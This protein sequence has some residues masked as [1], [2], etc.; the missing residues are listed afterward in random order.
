MGFRK[1][2]LGREARR[3]IGLVAIETPVGRH[4]DAGWSPSRRRLVAV[5]ILGGT[6]GTPYYSGLSRG[7]EL[8]LTRKLPSLYKFSHHAF[9]LNAPKLGWGCL[10]GNPNSSCPSI[11][12]P[13]AERVLLDRSPRAADGARG[14][15]VGGFD[16]VLQ[17]SLE[18][19][20]PTGTA[21]DLEPSGVGSRVAASAHG[22]DPP[23]DQ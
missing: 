21:G 4:R 16:S 14:T 3:N 9:S 1:L 22:C 20:M 12:N 18:T 23:H 5:E 7:R 13:R 2:I 19:V 6:I 15:S 8:L 11:R 10:H 17:T